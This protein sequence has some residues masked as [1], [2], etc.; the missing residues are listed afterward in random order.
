M[1]KILSSVLAVLLWIPLIASC[2]REP[3]GLIEAEV[4]TIR[5]QAPSQSKLKSMAG[6]ELALSEGHYDLC[7]NR[8]AAA[9]RA[10]SGEESATCWYRASQC[11]ARA[12]DYKTSQFHVQTAASSGFASLQTLRSDPLL[13]PLR[14][15]A[16]WTLVDD[17]VKENHLARSVLEGAVTLCQTHGEAED[18]L[19]L[20]A[21]L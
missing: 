8:F 10:S 16:H 21:T 7:A 1:S 11:A 15:G 2:E 14:S 9:A 19:L 4:P 17:L 12:G 20:G 3:V 18:A 6:A 5:S 13:R